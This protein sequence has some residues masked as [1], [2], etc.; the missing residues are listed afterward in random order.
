[1]AMRWAW[2]GRELQH[3]LQRE[4][5]KEEELSNELLRVTKDKGT[6]RDTHPEADHARGPP[7]FDRGRPV[8]S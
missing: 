8:S 7:V 3:G 2:K 5:V 1:L 4:A 6:E